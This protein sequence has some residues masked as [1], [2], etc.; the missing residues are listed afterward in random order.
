MCARTLKSKSM[1]KSIWI[2]AYLII[3]ASSPGSS[4]KQQYALQWANNWL[5]TLESIGA[6][7]TEHR[8]ALWLAFGSL[9]TVQ[10]TNQRQA[11]GVTLTEH[12]L[13]R[14]N[15]LWLA[16]VI[17]SDLILWRNG[18]NNACKI[19]PN[20]SFFGLGNSFLDE[21]GQTKSYGCPSP[22]ATTL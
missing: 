1:F 9:C 15:A 3:E 18:P 17:I 6:R 16:R 21:C 7:L 14:Q 10:L 2:Y 11:T 4:L 8:L 12:H 5:T 19:L 13:Q 22:R 20:G